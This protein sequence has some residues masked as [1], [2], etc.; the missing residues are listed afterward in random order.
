M[1]KFS[2]EKKI[3]AVV[4]SLMMIIGSIPIIYATGASA[5][6][7][8]SKGTTASQ[9][10]A[11]KPTDTTEDTGENGGITADKFYYD[12]DSKVT[13]IPSEKQLDFSV[14]TRIYNNALNKTDDVLKNILKVSA[15]FE[16]PEKTIEK[17]IDNKYI[18]YSIDTK[19]KAK[20]LIAKIS[21]P[22]DK[23]YQNKIFSIKITEKITE[24]KTVKFEGQLL[25]YSG[26]PEINNIEYYD[27]Q[28][29]KISKPKWLNGNVKINFGITSS[30]PVEKVNV[31]KV[32]DEN[33]KLTVTDNGNGTYSVVVKKS[34]LYTI[35]AVDKLGNSVALNTEKIQIDTTAPEMSYKFYEG[36]TNAKG[37]EL[38]EDEWSNSSIV[39]EATLSETESR[40][41]E[42]TISVCL[43][44]MPLPK[45]KVKIETSSDMMKYV[46][47]FNAEEKAD[48]VITC[49][50]EAG[51]ELPDKNGT[52]SADE[53]RLDKTAPKARDF[54]LYFKK[55]DNVEDRIL[56]LLTFGLYSNNNIEVTISVA[57][58]N[59]SAING[60]FLYSDN[61]N[62]SVTTSQEN[63]IVENGSC[64]EKKFILSKSGEKLSEEFDLMVRAEDK[65]GN[66]SG[67]LKLSNNSINTKISIS[68][69]ETIEKF[70]RALGKIVISNSTPVFDE[71]SFKYEGFNTAKISEKTYLSGVGR[72]SINVEES[73]V[74]L[75]KIRAIL[76]KGL[77]SE[78]I[79]NSVDF[80]KETN[81]KETYGIKL[82]FDTT[83]VENGK[84]SVTFLA[85]GNN[86]NESDYTVEFY[87]DNEAPKL[88]KNGINY[89]NAMNGGQLWTNKDVKVSFNFDEV[90]NI[91]EVTCTKGD[92]KYTVNS[93]EGKSEYH[94][95]TDEYGVYTIT[96]EDDLGNSETYDTAPVL[97]DKKEPNVVKDSIKLSNYK[98]TNQDVTVS[99]SVI[100]EL[101]DSGVE[102]S[103]A[104]I[105][106]VQVNGG[107]IKCTKN[108]EEDNKYSFIA[109]NNGKYTVKVSDKAGNSL[110]KE[111][112]VSNIDKTAPEISSV[113]ISAAKNN[114]SFGMYHNED[115]TMTVVVN[116]TPNSENDNNHSDLN[117]LYV[118][119]MNNKEEL[120][121]S[122]KDNSENTVTYE[123]I[124]E[125]KGDIQNAVNDI[126]KFKFK[127][128]DTAGN[129]ISTTLGANGALVN[130]DDISD[131]D[132]Y[133]VVATLTTPTI[134]TTVNFTNERKVDGTT[135]YSG[136]GKIKATLKD[137]ISGIDSYKTYFVKTGDIVYDENNNISN[138]DSLSEYESKGENSD[139]EKVTSINVKI[140]TPNKDKLDS[141]EYT[142][143]IVAKNLSGNTLV[144]TKDIVV[145]NT[146][147]RVTDVS[148]SGDVRACGENGIYTNGNSDTTVKVG[149]SDENGELLVAGL[150]KVVLKAKADGKEIT[151][152]SKEITTENGKSF[153][154]FKLEPSYVYTDISFVVYDNF[155]NN[156]EQKL[157]Y[158]DLSVINSKQETETVKPDKENFEIVANIDAEKSTYTTPKFDFKYS[159]EEIMLYKY[160][161]NGKGVIS[162]TVKNEFSGIADV[163]VKLDNKVVENNVSRTPSTDSCNKT[164]SVNT[165]V[166]IKNLKVESGEHKIEF[167]ATDN[168]GVVK[169]LGTTIFY[170]DRTNPTVDKITFS[171]VT[172]PS[173]TDKFLNLLTFGLYS[174][175]SIE[176][177]VEVSDEGP[178]SSIE[179]D[180]VTLTSNTGKEIKEKTKLEAV[181]ES[182]TYGKKLYTKTFTLGASK[183]SETSFYN[184]LKASVADKFENANSNDVN[185]KV[186]A[187][188]K[189][190]KLAP[191]FDIVATKKAPSINNLKSSLD[192][193]K[194]KSYNRSS[195]DTQWFQNNPTVT[196]DVTD[197]ISKIHSIKVTVNEVD[198]TE[199]CTCTCTYADEVV[200]SGKLLTEFTDFTE[201]SGNKI[202]SVNVKLEPTKENSM[203]MKEGENTVTVIAKG[204]NGNTS[205]QEETFYIDTTDPEV[206]GFDFTENSPETKHSVEKTNYG[207]FFKNQTKVTVSAKDGNGV[208]VNS[209]SFYTVDI[210]GIKSS[211]VT[212]KAVGNKA[213]FV[214]KANFKGK[215][216]AYVN[217][218]VNNE[219]D[220]FTPDGVIAET[221]G[222]HN[223][224][225]FVK[226]SKPDTP[227]RDI[228]GKD[229]YSDSINVS[230]D[231]A[232][233]YAGIKSVVYS[234]VS[235]YDTDNN[236]S[237]I[238][239][240]NAN[241]EIAGW[242]VVKKDNNLATELSKT[243]T[244]ANNSNDIKVWVK[245]TDNA[246]FSTEKE[247]MFSIDKTSPKID[248]KYDVNNPNR[249]N[250]EDFYKTD[251]TATVTVTERNFN[252]N[253]FTFNITNTDSV[254]PQLSAGTNWTS[255]TPDATNPDLTVHT[256]TFTFHNDGDYT[257]D[258]G[259]KDLAGRSAN[260]YGT[261]K[262]TVDQTIPKISVSYDKNNGSSYFD[263]KR[264][265]T[266][267]IDEHN[268]YAPYV[269]IKQAAFAADNSTPATPPVVSGWSTNGNI[270]TATITF[271]NDG[272]YSFTVDFKDK[273][274]NQAV[275]D[276]E[277]EFYIDT[278]VDK[279]EIVNVE[280]M[281]AYDG[282]I[283]PVIK[284]FDNN[285]ASS[286]YRLEKISVDKDLAIVNDLIANDSREAG[287]SRVISYN[288]FPS[289]EENDGIY[290]LTASIVDRAGNKNQKS[291]MFSV[292]R[293]GSTFMIKD[294]ATKELV[295]DK[296]YTNDAPNIVITEVN[297]N[298]VSK[299]VIQLNR[300]DT[301]Q[302]LAYGNDYT[303]KHTGGQ[304]SWHEYNYTVLKKNFET[305]GN[306]V[307]TLT[308]T[309]HFKNVVSNRT[310]YKED[311]ID[312][313]CPVE[314]T[315][316]KT[317]PIVTIS[318][319]ESNQYYEDAEKEV[320]VVC[321]DANISADQLKVTFDGKELTKDDYQLNDSTSGSIELK[322]SL[323]ADGNDKDRTFKVSIADK[324]GNINEDGE[325][326]GFRLSASWIARVLHYQLPLVIGIGAALVLLIGV[327][328]FIFAK[329]RKKEEA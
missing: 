132:I 303:V 184:D 109:K 203:N 120:K 31:F 16:N 220:D 68:D 10:E 189:E 275:Q 89:S 213:S 206:D 104:G 193:S 182:E 235:P 260:N 274:T 187:Y 3:L 36:T 112:S 279:L 111:I 64:Y 129:E 74:G 221:E 48:Y 298:E 2:F 57:D 225:S 321:D 261:D 272:K 156:Q 7:T 43:N 268:F 143:I 175:K 191:D 30:I 47:S 164:V 110:E 73:I 296:Y 90:T 310:A 285:Y 253:D 53:I 153:A 212:E 93:D 158:F 323:A 327:V 130:V 229:L 297:V 167:I 190:I 166:D 178:S 165:E 238:S 62:I 25:I 46:V 14:K 81:K 54:T 209:I 286:D 136:Q 76:D 276:R 33:N 289:V 150:Q 300:D 197:N 32:D 140:D 126:R 169:S 304:T 216:Y 281:I 308:S 8:A 61:E 181:G 211:V 131:E 245:V 210:N 177:K 186:Y 113:V 51:I 328:I 20:Y 230:F 170:I 35:E 248:V 200:Y 283:A 128:S 231:V 67:K 115:L 116:N 9:D 320:T 252:K 105:D 270:S 103:C 63:N 22:N 155:D 29:T 257:F 161:D 148:V 71:D 208:G 44:N 242:N 264:T 195:D 139:K 325:V 60:I 78:K 305:E 119:N 59:L 249:V 319:I 202:S 134:E 247:I 24:K 294:N 19:N 318:G 293:F 267:T 199:N 324:A 180:K 273:A 316:D 251:R 27:S 291:V 6:E 98:W 50:N 226:I 236:I 34:G 69:L 262:F 135:V 228:N 106:S 5:D 147:P 301:T 282:T 38:S 192:E 309:D 114:K 141:G 329:K 263:G 15:V 196:F 278:K 311:K 266:I 84:H 40:I 314:F 306:Y 4:L 77:D 162:T 255:Y 92:N 121:E 96:A 207:Y 204:N 99:F 101:L 66:S 288:N 102:Q 313:T 37:K 269:D 201:H 12:K 233:T 322:L 41:D 21:I 243:I 280:N 149:V 49:K 292:N 23:Q 287:F 137:E 284:C 83:N 179:N 237:V 205:K 125:P 138:L 45:D 277:K 256:A 172:N 94:F 302:T 56:N 244:V 144:R 171:K 26:Q 52:I 232:S 11:V 312:R 241:G 88:S 157:V 123:Y 188:G 168:C 317:A 82:K 174:N 173:I 223:A 152:E 91:K 259:F 65:A 95:T 142:A 194:G 160:N 58:D 265:A 227:Y 146:V 97:I 118:E 163:E 42:R 86:N 117:D 79:L 183:V 18:T 107:N 122:K 133:E 108:S 254:T 85:T 299:P 124:I 100:D 224:N 154:E 198:V 239:E 17:T 1:K 315:V 295:Q 185:T 87:V 250:G 222:Q 290:K 214:V 246:G 80:S 307:L 39:A 217:D 28:N 72:I 240:T 176:V 326:N 258:C 70:S 219:S 234:V 151:K 159:N 215:I 127:A 75:N 218:F 145:D 271:A 55:A 13:Y